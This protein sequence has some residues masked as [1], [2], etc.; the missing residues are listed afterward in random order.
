M[1]LVLKM[2][3]KPEK[4]DMDRLFIISHV[5]FRMIY[6]LELYQVQFH[7]LVQR[8]PGVE[9]KDN[10]VYGGIPATSFPPPETS[11]QQPETYSDRSIFAG[12]VPAP[13]RM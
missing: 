7:S 8:L 9:L 11:G 6:T 2:T 4:F 12:F 3:H 5:T 10:N 1:N 13:L